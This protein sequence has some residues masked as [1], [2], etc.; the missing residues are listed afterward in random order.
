MV[1]A[2]KPKHRRAFWLKQLHT[3]HWVSAAICLV[4][5]L[6]FAIT[7]ITLN[8]ATHIEASP[9]VTRA[10]AELPAEL[11]KNLTPAAGDLETP[12]GIASETI[13]ALHGLSVA[14][15][16]DYRKFFMDDETRY[17]HTIDP[18]TGRPVVGD[19]ASVSMLHADCI[20]ADALATVLGVLGVTD[21]MVWARER[22]IAARFLSREGAGFRERTTP[23]FD[24]M[25][26]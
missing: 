16:G 14:T 23:A 25:L 2:A 15:S 19:L 12:A 21:G 5:M 6:L 26:G 20:R 9:R 8:N 4:G 11:L 17:A 13:V 7:G 1:T 3:W 22:S 18:R 24:A 10:A